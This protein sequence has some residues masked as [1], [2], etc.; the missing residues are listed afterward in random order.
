MGKLFW[1]ACGVAFVAALGIWGALTLPM[2]GQVEA[3][4]GEVDKFRAELH[5]WADEGREGK[6]KEIRNQSS[7]A[8]ANAY[9]KALA[10]EPFLRVAEMIASDAVVL[11]GAPDVQGFHADLLGSFADLFDR[12]FVEQDRGGRQLHVPARLLRFIRGKRGRKR[13]R[14]AADRRGRDDAAGGANEIATRD[15]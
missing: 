13:G 11:E 3:K 15:V 4:R 7:I 2:A 9:T 5:K 12:Q 10:A 1:I 14:D 8:A 6:Y